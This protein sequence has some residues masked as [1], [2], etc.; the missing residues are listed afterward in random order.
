MLWR[1]IFEGVV[2]LQVVRDDEARHCPFQLRDGEFVRLTPRPP[3]RAER[4]LHV[5]AERDAMWPIDFHSLSLWL[6]AGIFAIGNAPL[7]AGNLFGGTAMQMAILAT[8]VSGLAGL[9]ALR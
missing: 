3:G 5:A 7:V 6:N 1:R 4:F 9:Y 2:I 8:Y